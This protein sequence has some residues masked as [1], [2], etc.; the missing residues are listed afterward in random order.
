MHYSEDEQQATAWASVSFPSILIAIIVIIA[1]R[2]KYNQ[3]Q[4]YTF[5]FLFP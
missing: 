5:F 2:L 1:Y 3:Q 4:H